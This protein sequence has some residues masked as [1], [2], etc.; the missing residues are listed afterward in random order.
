MF[1]IDTP[2]L[3]SQNFF[4]AQGGVSLSNSLRM[5]LAVA[6]PLA[7]WGSLPFLCPL[8]WPFKLC[9]PPTSWSFINNYHMCLGEPVMKSSNCLQ[10]TWA[11]SMSGWFGEL[12]P[13]LMPLYCQIL[14]SL[15]QHMRWS[16][17]C[18]SHLRGGSGWMVPACLTWLFL[19]LCCFYGIKG[20]G[21]IPVWRAQEEP[22]EVH[23]HHSSNHLWNSNL[24]INHLGNSRT[25]LLALERSTAT[26]GVGLIQ[27]S[28]STGMKK[29]IVISSDGIWA[30]QDSLFHT[31]ISRRLHW[32]GCCGEVILAGF[33]RS[34]IKDGTFT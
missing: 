22:L 4:V 17:S 14:S 16:H 5:P 12:Q 11:C 13:L 21:V 27:G 26:A 33:L 19:V 7:V 10:T 8:L 6:V 20:D 23:G 15:W 34:R 3:S 24:F 25:T 29:C 30:E 1:S 9:W 2:A 18:H 32:G 31:E 28:C